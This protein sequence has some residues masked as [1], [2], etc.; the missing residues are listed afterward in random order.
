[1]PRPIFDRPIA[2]R[3]LHERERGVIEN[4]ASAFARA[5][6]AGYHIELD[7]QLTRDG[8]PVAFH[9]DTLQRL[10]GR[11]GTP[12]GLSAAEMT[13]LPLLGS[14]SGDCPRRFT[15][16]LAQ[17]KGRTLLQVE[18]KQQPMRAANEALARAAVAAV[19]GYNG[20][21]VFESF[22][23]GLVS[24]VR[25]FGFA[26]PV[27]II[28]YRYDQ[29]EWDGHLGTWRRF[30]LRHLLHWPWSQFDF[31]S[32]NEHALSLPAVRFWRALG[33]PVTSW[34]IRS[35]DDALKALRGGADQ[36]VFEGFTPSA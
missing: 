34:T 28:T 9:D 22:D 32:A 16:V 4:S 19:A 8:V 30:V 5:I 17:V 23:P 15:D 11:E 31:I 25:R 2:H 27:G 20:P 7:L 18:L 13:A 1:M 36:I 35:A 6:E 29:P 12:G 33:K 26:G 21:L 10:L 3:G 14:A 24:S